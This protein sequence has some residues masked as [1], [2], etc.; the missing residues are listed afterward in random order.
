MTP[1][2][3]K[4]GKSLDD[5]PIIKE[6]IL[7]EKPQRPKS[8]QTIDIG[9][10]ALKRIRQLCLERGVTFQDFV[11]RAINQE[12]RAAGEPSIEEIEAEQ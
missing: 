10:K 9:R 2:T 6:P 8:K 5:A 3:S 1:A 4:R 7:T 12:L 11:T